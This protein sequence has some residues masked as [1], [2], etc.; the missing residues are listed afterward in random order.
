M[1]E[2]KNLNYSQTKI[3]M[4]YRFKMIEEIRNGDRSIRNLLNS[5]KKKK[6]LFQLYEEYKKNR[7]DSSITNHITDKF[8]EESSY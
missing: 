3:K 8:G 2:H 1:H 5:Q 7:V 4:N 6:N